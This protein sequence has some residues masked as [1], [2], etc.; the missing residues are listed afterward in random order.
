VS[1]I[2]CDFRDNAAYYRGGAIHCE[3]SYLTVRDC[4]FRNNTSWGYADLCAGAAISVAS[5]S[6][7]I[8]DCE[9]VGN[10][11]RDGAA[12]R[13]WSFVRIQN[14][15]LANNSAEDGSAL[16]IGIGIIERCVVAFTD[17]GQGVSCEQRTTFSNCI[18]YGNAEGDSLC[19]NYSDNLFV[20]PLMCEPEN[21]NIGLCADSPCLPGNNPWGVLV[22]A[23]GQEC[24]PCGSPVEAHSWTSIKALYR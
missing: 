1:V 20:D 18:V 10:S 8:S 17:P 6:A 11:S 19:S 24:G 2:D 5:Y 22:G 3:E 21:D 9:F 12:V 13:G 14:C 23:R 15:S 16:T 4:S 7:D